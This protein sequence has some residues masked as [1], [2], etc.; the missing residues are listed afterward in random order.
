VDLPVF[1]VFRAEGISSFLAQKVIKVFLRSHIK[2]RT[3]PY[4][5][6]LSTFLQFE[7][8]PILIIIERVSDFPVTN[9]GQSC[10]IF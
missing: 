10:F 4:C 6:V 2:Y 9:R 3:V 1:F 7:I 8:T 5:T